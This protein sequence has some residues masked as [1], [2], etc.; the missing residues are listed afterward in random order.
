MKR[1]KKK[2]FRHIENKKLVLSVYLILRLLVILVMV[3]Q[4]VNHNYENVYICIL[5]LLLFTL[6][7][8]VERRFHVDLPDTLEIIVLIIIFATEILGEIE[9]YYVIFSHW[10]TVMHT[11]NGFLFAALG[12]SVVNVLNENKRISMTLSPF[13]VALTAF[14]FS[15]TIGVLWE[16][17]EWGMD[18]LFGLD[19]QKDTIVAAFNSVSLDPGGHNIPYH[20]QNVADVILVFG[21]GSQK[22]LG[23]GGYLDIGLIDTMS[24]LFVNFIGA[25]VFSVIGYFYVKSK[26]KGRFAKLFIPEVM[27]SGEEKD[28]ESA[29]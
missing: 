27:D 21:D 8:I 28:C 1:A 7:S 4:I 26:G 10:D 23:L 18:S 14:C 17:F 2:G 22:A 15:M 24:D 9:E 16:F 3:A 6:P 29:E 13:Y 19:M 20:V 5:T 11:I 25:V 12:F